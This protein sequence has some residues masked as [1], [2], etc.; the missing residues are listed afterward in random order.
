M[1]E[2]IRILF[3]A[4]N[5]KDIDPIRLGAELRAIDERIQS[6]PFRDQ[7]TLIP[8]FAV[9]PGDLLST[10][11]RYKP[12]ILHFSGHGSPS[13]GIVA[14]SESG[15][16]RLVSTKA[17]ASVFAIIKDNLRLVVLNSCYSSRQ[18]RGISQIIEFT[19]GMRHKIGDRSAIEFSAAFYLS[20]A[21][22]RSV[23]EC[24]ELGKSALPIHNL[25]DAHIPRLLVRKGA[26]ASQ[27]YL[28]CSGS[29]SCRQAT[30]AERSAESRRKSED[31]TMQI[32]VIVMLKNTTKVI[33][34]WRYAAAQDRKVFITLDEDRSR[35]TPAAA[36][37]RLTLKINQLVSDNSG[38][39][40]NPPP[41]LFLFLRGNLI[42]SLCD[43]HLENMITNA[44]DCASGGNIY[45]AWDQDA[46]FP[47]LHQR[48]ESVLDKWFR[49]LLNAGV[50]DLIEIPG[51][52]RLRE[53]DEKRILRDL[54]R[55]SE[56]RR[57]RMRKLVS[58]EG[59][60]VVLR[61]RAFSL[62]EFMQSFVSE[63]LLPAQGKNLAVFYDQRPRFGWSQL[64]KNSRQLDRSGNWFI[65]TLSRNVRDSRDIAEMWSQ[66]ANDATSA[67]FDGLFEFDGN[68]PWLYALFRLL[69]ASRLSRLTSTTVAGKALF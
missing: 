48:Y 20:L 36:W 52:L 7:L 40:T 47:L 6:A 10:L 24:F 68:F 21:H 11:L 29:E 56:V 67:R 63:E 64:L 5:P 53:S 58:D 8:H 57:A 65:G 35:L 9:R 34:S 2:P 19:V 44:R 13:G 59:W 66:E 50:A 23:K 26:D 38:N 15:H 31:A 3:L 37:Q 16:T 18:A 46:T 30:G 42:E 27:A 41:N 60:D 1:T 54:A 17:L 43:D 4:A 22:G 33:E 55:D 28:L 32:D 14:E 51:K 39:L 62:K 25:P 49:M 45:I 12:H 61:D 69:L